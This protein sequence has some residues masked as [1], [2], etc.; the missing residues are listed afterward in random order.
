MD[1]L[2]TDEQLTDAVRLRVQ[3]RMYWEQI[4]AKLGVERRTLYN[5]RQTERWVAAALAVVSEIKAEA[6]PV[7]WQGLL[8]AA[9]LKDV[10]ACKEI[11]NRVDE[12][13]EEKLRIYD[14]EARD[15]LDAKLANIAARRRQEGS[16]DK[17][18]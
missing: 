17:S 6:F 8:D 15:K 3:E 1:T 9:A 2:L 14:G 11:L 4:A 5:A 12:V 18:N 7:A 13:V 16:A 10:A